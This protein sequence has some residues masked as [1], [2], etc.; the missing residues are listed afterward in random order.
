MPRGLYANI[1]ARRKAGTSRPKSR[2][3]IKPSVYKAMK[4]RTGKFKPK[5]K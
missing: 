4:S 5:K 3:T 1:N 2:S